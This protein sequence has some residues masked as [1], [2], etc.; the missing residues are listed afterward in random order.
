M[1][2]SPH[3]QLGGQQHRLK[4]RELSYSIQ[5]SIYEYQ[6]Q[7][8]IY[9]SLYQ[10]QFLPFL[11]S[12]NELQVRPCDNYTTIRKGVGQTQN[13]EYFGSVKFTQPKT[14]VFGVQL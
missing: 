8:V 4:L 11:Q 10:G 5:S 7:K 13:P 3:G 9:F 12:E 2:L 6:N 14:Q 1:I